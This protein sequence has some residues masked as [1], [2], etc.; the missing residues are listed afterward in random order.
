MLDLLKLQ[1]V[2]LVALYPKSEFHMASF[3]NRF[4]SD[5]DAPFTLSQQ[6]FILVAYYLKWPHLTRAYH[7]VGLR[8]TDVVLTS[9]LDLSHPLLLSLC[10]VIWDAS[11]SIHKTV[12]SSSRVNNSKQKIP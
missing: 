5:T 3:S 6:P 10:E 9:R 7:C 1:E 4:L 12:L 8:M 11:Y 2:A